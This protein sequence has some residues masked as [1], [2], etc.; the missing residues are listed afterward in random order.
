VVL[1]L[2]KSNNGVTLTVKDNGPGLSSEATAKLFQPFFTTKNHGTGLGLAV[3]Q[4]IVHNHD[5]QIIA[6]NAPD[7]G[8]VFTVF[9][10]YHIR[11]DGKVTKIDV[12]IIAMDNFVRYPC[13]QALVSANLTWRKFFLLI[14][15]D[16]M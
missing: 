13:E 2:Q 3:V 16:P 14:G 4:A 1:N 8:A 11:L 15:G 10:P 12:L 7:G 6:V 9:L 5:G